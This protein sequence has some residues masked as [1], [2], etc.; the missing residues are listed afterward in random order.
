[1][2]VFKPLTV[3]PL[4]RCFEQRG[5]CW[6][7]VT[8]LV[9]VDL[10]RPVRA[11]L[12]KDLW[13]FWAG[14]PEAEAPLDDGILRARAEYLVSGF[15][16][17]H[18]TDGR[19]CAVAAEVGQLQKEL[20]VR[21][22]RLWEG[23]RATSPRPFERMPLR[24]SH[25][26]GGAGFAA[27][28][29]GKGAA[30]VKVDGMQLHFLPNIEDPR[31]PLSLSSQAGAPAGFGPIDQTWPQRAAF[32][33]R[34]DEA[35]LKNEF[36]AIAS[37]TDWRFF[38]IA[39]ED[40]QQIEPFR[41]D[42]RYAFR[43][44]HPNRPV[45][46]GMLPG[47]RA[48][49]FVTHRAGGEEKFKEVRLRL[50]TLWFFP[51]AERAVLAFQGMHE[52]A[53]DDGA[54]I[55]HLLAALEYLDQPRP[56]EHYLAVRDKR[57]DRTHGAIESMREDDLMPADLVVPLIDFAPVENRALARWQQ[58][59]EAHRAEAR[60]TVAAHGMDPDDGHAPAVKGPAQPEIR[61]LDDLMQVQQK[62]EAQ[63]AAMRKQGEE[64]KAAALH[65]I[66]AIFEREKMDFGVIER[67]MSGMDTRGPPKPF[68]EALVASFNEFIERGK[69]AK[70]DVSELEQM[71]V[72]QKIQRQWQDGEKKQMMGYR[73]LAHYQIPA[74]PV[75]G[76]AGKALRQRV[77]AHHAQQ[78]S[79]R[80]WDLTGADLSG[81]DLKGA[82]LEGALME[83]TNLT[84]THLAEANL[85]DAVLAHATLLSTQCQGAKLAHANLGGA[86]IEKA[87]FAGADLT[88]AILVKARLFDVSLRGARLDGI[89]IDD[90]MLAGLDCSG[91]VSE[92][93]LVFFR[94]DLRGC[95]FA[96]ARFK[97]CVFI[98]CNLSG[99]DLSDAEFEKCGFVALQ[100]ERAVFK[101]LHIASGCFAQGCVLTAADFTG[102]R[103]ANMNFRGAAL[104]GAVFRG[105]SLQGSD[106]SECD[107]SQADFRQADAR[108]ARFVRARLT[109]TQFAAANL[110]EAI[111][112][113][114]VLD[115]TDWRHA[116]LFQSDFAR[117]RLGAG[118]RFDAALTTRMRTLPRH[119][120]PAAA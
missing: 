91:A 107:L 77:A 42:E 35:W 84:G 51:D 62:M 82:D 74:D 83:R 92:A 3:S 47:L 70:G 71:V 68:A 64:A 98:E 106:F 18:G 87:D 45:L 37:D 32:H 96:R 66:K 38:N 81:M 119:R 89:R 118:L 20:L 48:R 110:M 109:R 21:G 58:R 43:N 116:N 4:V 63:S 28:P 13:Q 54:D 117:V 113:H 1:M 27:N 16:Y 57:L 29:L 44:M 86:R 72:D 6:M 103:L 101:G 79:F 105:A 73:L 33:G 111:F 108:Q 14:R 114:A 8:G 11:H 39:P 19:A 115:E 99:A 40:Q 94:R 30:P 12:E 102:A 2:K 26:Y 95:S 112:Q 9:M 78:Q 80:N 85:Q 53:E 17:P 97:Q 69:A 90:A 24:W 76:E 22:E 10:G 25:A 7:G 59:A 31:Q 67:E 5:R 50:N 15:A 56:A 36:P 55:I 49:A 65:D 61:S 46:E 75:E 34:Y 23:E 104:H 88:D 120:P 60:K 52:I 100:A 93:M 41:G